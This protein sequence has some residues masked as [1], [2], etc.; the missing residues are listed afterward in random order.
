[1]TAAE[2]QDGV[3]SETQNPEGVV[4]VGEEDVDEVLRQF[5][6]YPRPEGK[7]GKE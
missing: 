6:I 4:V 5:N 2:L 7:M 1:M 3:G